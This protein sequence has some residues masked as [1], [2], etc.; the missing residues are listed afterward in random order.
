MPPSSHRVLKRKGRVALI[1]TA[2][3]TIGLAY[4]VRI[5]TL[6]L[7]QGEDLAQAERQF[8]QATLPPTQ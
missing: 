8:E 7:W 4:S 2:N 1:E 6:G 5:G 3:P